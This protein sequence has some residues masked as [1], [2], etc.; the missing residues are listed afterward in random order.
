MSTNPHRR[1]SDAQ[2][3]DGLTLRAM[4]VDDNAD[5]RAYI[6]ALVRRF[7]FHVTSLDDGARALDLLADDG[8]AFDLLI[9]DCEMPRMGG[10]EVIVHV[11]SRA[12]WAEVY[13]MM[14]TGREDVETKISALR[15]GYD[16]FLSKSSPEIEIVAKLGAA[17]RVISRQR[18]LDAAVHELYGLATRDELTGVFNRRFFFSEAERLLAD[19]A[20][21]SLI[22]FDLDDFKR[23]NDT[24]GHLAGDRMLRDVGAL[25]FRRTR[26]EDLIARYGGDE[27]VMLV[28]G[29]ELPEVEATGARI[30]AE[31]ATMQWTFGNDVVSVGVTTGFAYAQLL[32]S[33]TVPQLLNAGDRDLYKNKWLRRNPDADPSLYEYGGGQEADPLEF[34]APGGADVRRILSEE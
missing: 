20:A 9:V 34:H 19:N 16:D 32:D 4:V 24:F 31:I 12:R 13:A 7:G 25:F 18:R 11:R 2:A 27:F 15:L 1:R 29:L 14:L 28:S 33:P 3:P 6:S 22:F 26:H 8:S 23:I 30:A 10:L 17:R 21:V 5:Y